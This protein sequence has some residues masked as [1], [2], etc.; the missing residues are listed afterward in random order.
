LKQNTDYELKVYY[1]NKLL[2]DVKFK[3]KLEPVRFEV[4]N[5]TGLV[6]NR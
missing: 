2:D 3:T 1:K 4:E 6:V 5:Y